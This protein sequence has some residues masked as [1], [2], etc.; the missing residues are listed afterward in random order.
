MGD[1]VLAVTMGVL[2]GL[3]IVRWMANFS[4]DVGADPEGADMA[5]FQKVGQTKVDRKDH[6]WYQI[7]SNDKERRGWY[8]CILC[9]AMTRKVPPSP[10][11]CD[12]VAPKF[13]KVTPE[14]RAMCP[15]VE[16]KV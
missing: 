6:I 10:T 8:K 15:Y 14:E 5:V 4:I 13:E 3:L 2:S 9:G 1:A 12:W 16:I 11:P 7:V